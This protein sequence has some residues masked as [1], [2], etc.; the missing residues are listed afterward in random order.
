MGLPRQ[1]KKSDPNRTIGILLP[2]ILISRMIFGL[3]LGQGGAE[4]LGGDVPRVGGFGERRLP[5]GNPQGD[6]CTHVQVEQGG[7]EMAGTTGAVT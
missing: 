1:S 5:L 6:A 4:D 7:E 2:I 3:S